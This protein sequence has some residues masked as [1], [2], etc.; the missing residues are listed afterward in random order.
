MYDLIYG[1][2]FI[3]KTYLA[4]SNGARKNSIV[5]QTLSV[6][7]GAAHVTEK[8]MKQ[9]IKRKYE[10]W[11]CGD[12]AST[13]WRVLVLIIGVTC[14]VIPQVLRV[15]N[16]GSFFGN[17]DLASYIFFFSSLIPKI[18]IYATV[19]LFLKSGSESVYASWQLVTAL[20]ALPKRKME[21]MVQ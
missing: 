2:F 13:L 17:N 21:Q 15:L 14:A 12:L 16:G 5:L 8:A 4:P 19:L 9:S 6:P 18:F 3:D 11:S 10:F 1:T 20:M 7:E